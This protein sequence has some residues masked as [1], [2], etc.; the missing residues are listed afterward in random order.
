MSPT[1]MGNVGSETGLELR[2]R[3][4]VEVKARCQSGNFKKAPV[5]KGWEFQGKVRTE[6]T[7]LRKGKGIIQGDTEG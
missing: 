6:D 5:N 2:S 3:D 7:N 1:R 4:D